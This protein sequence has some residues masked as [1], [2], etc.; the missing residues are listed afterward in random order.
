MAGMLHA[1][2][3]RT[4]LWIGGIGAAAVSRAVDIHRREI[5]RACAG[6]D[7]RVRPGAV[8]LTGNLVTASMAVWDAASDGVT[9]PTAVAS[10]NAALGEPARGFAEPGAMLVEPLDA[11]RE[12]A[13]AIHESLRALPE[14][15]AL[16][17]E[18]LQA[19]PE[20]SGLAREPLAAIPEVLESIPEA[21]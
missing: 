5:R 12:T 13:G 3:I 18:A 19:L 11:L 16:V 10:P 15:S 14:A 1:V 21:P 7:G 6:G 2:S 4:A 9:R 17:R 8:S 20:A